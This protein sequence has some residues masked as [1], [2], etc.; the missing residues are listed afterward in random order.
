MYYYYK[1]REATTIQHKNKLDIRIKNVYVYKIVTE[2][3]HECIEILKHLRAMCSIYL[4][5]C[6]YYCF[7]FLQITGIILL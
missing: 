5:W 1:K 2:N 3:K 6:F 4:K 7:Y